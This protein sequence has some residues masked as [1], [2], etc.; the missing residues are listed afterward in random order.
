MSRGKALSPQRREV[1]LVVVV[2]MFSIVA[3]AYIV[4]HV[5]V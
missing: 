2:L 5:W 3:L 4:G 1:L